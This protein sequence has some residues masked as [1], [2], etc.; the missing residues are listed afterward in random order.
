M[1]QE[2]L[3]ISAGGLYLLNKIFFSFSERTAQPSRRRQWQIASWIVYLGGLPEWVIL[4]IMDAY[5]MSRR[6]PSPRIA[7]NIRNATA[8]EL[9]PSFAV[10]L[11]SHPDAHI[12]F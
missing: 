4:F 12:S 5:R 9:E 1:E 6:Q 2:V 8:P 7:Q 10:I 3:Q 11:T